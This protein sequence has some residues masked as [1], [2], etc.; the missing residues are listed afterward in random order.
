M[1]EY[2]NERSI[3]IRVAAALHNWQTE[4]SP[5][6]VTAYAFSREA[7]LLGSAALDDKHEA[8]IPVASPRE[9]LDIRIVL[10]PATP[11][12]TSPSLVD[13]LRRGAK[14]Q[15]VRLDPKNAE[16]A[17]VEFQIFPPIWECWFRGACFVSGTLLKRQ[18]S[19]GVSVNYPVCHARVEVYEV[20]PIW[21]ILDRLPDAAIDHL[22]TVV[23]GAVSTIPVPIPGPDP[24]PLAQ[25]ATIGPSV[26]ARMAVK[27]SPE[28]NG[29]LALLRIDH[30][31]RSIARLGS[32]SQFTQEISHYPEIIRPLICYFYPWFV[33]IEKVAEAYTDSCGHFYT[34]FFEGCENDDAPNLYFK[35]YQRLFG[36]SEVE[37]YGPT[38]IACHTRWDYVCGTEVTLT[39]TSPLAVACLPCP[40]VIGPD[41]WVL[42]T[43]I[44]NT[45]LKA[46]FGGGAPGATSANLGLLTSG[47]PWGGTLRPRLDFDN[48][49]RQ[50]LGVMYYQLSW[51]AGLSGTWTPMVAEVNRHYA[52]MV[53]TDLVISP[54]RLGPNPMVVGGTTLQLFEIP[55]AV[56]PLGQW[57]VPNGVLDTENGELDST[58]VSPGLA[59]KEDGSV[60]TG[61]TDG[62]G[63]FQL[64]LELFDA[65]GTLIDIAGAGIKYVVPDT[66]DL[67]GTIT[68][69]DASTVAQPGGGSLIVGS[70]MVLT[71]HVDNNHC[72][73]NL[74]PPTTAPSGGAADPCCGVVGYGAGDTC[75][76]PYTAYHP[77]GFATHSINV[78]RSA[79][80]I[81]TQTGG[82][83]NFNITDTVADMMS[84]DLPASCLGTPCVMAAFSEHLDVSEMATDGW[85]SGLGYNDTDDR[86]FA[87]APK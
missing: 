66:A 78:F 13:L 72:W 79:T 5:G 69:V 49:L 27:P 25:R 35:A 15:H 14:E 62:S 26:T 17:P 34:V 76:M 20:E 32:R 63:L 70:M 57:S 50:S 8:T 16:T 19:G 73:A 53:G 65:G 6:Q 44:G 64:Q 81:F 67:S 38:P 43:A 86:A 23:A 12:D 37:I 7:R 75:V 46:I 18:V 21:L 28:V 31:L 48:S 87:L 83:G 71:L 11:N 58:V 9:A 74:A 41:N 56:P 84:R 3:T 52:H 29:A 47:A 80:T 1:V 54:Y 40:P 55:P 10:G 22:K 77:H 36:F 42:F 24:A 82:V 33:T 4:K 51:R 85:G 30:P 45:S 60:V 68:T 61:T 2:A 39:T 59:F